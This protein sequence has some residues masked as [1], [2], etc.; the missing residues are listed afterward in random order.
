MKILEDNNMVYGLPQIEDKDNICEGCV[1]GKHYRNSFPKGGS[2]RAKRKL[3]LVHADV[4][5]RWGLIRL[6]IIGTLFFSLMI[7]R[8]WLGFILWNISKKCL[9]SLKILKVMLKSEVVVIFLRGDRG[10]KYTSREFNKFYE[11]EGVE[12]QLTVSY[13]PQQNGVSGKKKLNESGHGQIDD[14]RE[15]VTKYVLG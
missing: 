12:R 8:E 9:V 15:R 11:E 6:L 14:K 4:Y 3:E 13:T 5:G 1:M 2:W 10:K 7:I